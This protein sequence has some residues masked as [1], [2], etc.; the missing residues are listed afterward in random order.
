MKIYCVIESGGGAHE[1][2]E[3]VAM[4]TIKTLADQDV[5]KRHAAMIAR[6][7]SDRDIRVFGYRVEEREAVDELCEPEG[8]W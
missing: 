4:Y 6:G 2:E 1:P 5:E 3:I 7:S 8:G